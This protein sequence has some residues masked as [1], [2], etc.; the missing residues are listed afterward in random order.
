MRD[1]EVARELV[2]LARGLVSAETA[3][4]KRSILDFIKDNKKDLETSEYALI[5]IKLSG[6]SRDS[7][8]MNVDLEDLEKM[9]K[10]LR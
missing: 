10:A 5:R 3:Q 7:K 8:W 4:V 1:K 9:A 2:K 6:P